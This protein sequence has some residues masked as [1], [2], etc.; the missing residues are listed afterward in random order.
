MSLKRKKRY[1][2]TADEKE[3]ICDT[4][5]KVLSFDRTLSNIY[6]GG[7]QSN[8]SHIMPKKDSDLDV[9]IVTTEVKNIVNRSDKIKDNFSSY[10]NKLFQRYIDIVLIPSIYISRKDLELIK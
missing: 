9:Y 3:F 7:S 1:R 6:I 2:I 10:F 5:K 8:L 4:I